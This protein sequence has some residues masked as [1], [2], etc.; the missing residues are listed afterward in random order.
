MAA[1]EAR[2]RSAVTALVG[3]PVLA[4]ARDIHA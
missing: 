4:A 2:R 3:P 1:V